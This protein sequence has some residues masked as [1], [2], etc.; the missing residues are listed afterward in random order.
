MH[1]Y[2][3]FGFTSFVYPL[4]PPNSLYGNCVQSIVCIGIFCSLVVFVSVFVF[5]LFA[6]HSKNRQIASAVCGWLLFFLCTYYIQ[7]Q[8]IQTAKHFT[9]W[10]WL[11]WICAGRKP[12]EH[13]SHFAAFCNYMCACACSAWCMQHSQVHLSQAIFTRKIGQKF[14][15]KLFETIRNLKLLLILL[16]LLPLYIHYC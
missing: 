13:V 5:N 4:Y 15:S 8:S 12:D 9:V 7:I 3:F 11:V 10:N 2:F 6:K 16:L 14:S 1:N